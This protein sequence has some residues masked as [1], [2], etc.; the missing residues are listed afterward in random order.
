MQRRLLLSTLSVTGLTAGLSLTACGFK[1]RGGATFNFTSLFVSS[2]IVPPGPTALQL[3]R[4]LSNGQLAIVL[5]PL[6]KARTQAHLEVIS[7]SRERVVVGVSSAGQVR[8]FQ[9]RSRLRFRV[10]STAGQDLI[11]DSEIVQ[12]RD[13]SYSESAALAKEAE[14]ARLYQ[15]MQ[16]DIVQQVLRQLSAIKL[17]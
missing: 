2:A 12:Q 10:R 14:E 6:Q 17:A 5:D 9:L 7:E 8:E 15:D 3:L 13:I 16:N 11:A 1:M 4:A